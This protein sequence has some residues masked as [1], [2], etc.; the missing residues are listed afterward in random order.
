MRLDFYISTRSNQLKNRYRRG[1]G[2][3]FVRRRPD[4][5]P[6]PVRFERVFCSRDSREGGPGRE[7]GRGAVP[8]RH[9]RVESPVLDR[10]T[11]PSPSA[12]RG[13]QVA[14]TRAGAVERERGKRSTDRLKL[15]RVLQDITPSEPLPIKPEI[16]R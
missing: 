12:L 9:E 15:P 1:L 3:S 8:G 14:V 11:F 4:D 16:R 7:R 5:I 13:Q 2:P 6:I 10:D